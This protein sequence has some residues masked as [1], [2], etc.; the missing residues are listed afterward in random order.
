MPVNAVIQ[1]DLSIETK[2][3]YEY[4]VDPNANIQEELIPNTESPT[5][6]SFQL[7]F[8]HNHIVSEIVATID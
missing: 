3:T 7:E 6:T 4:C 8:S 5:M 1:T 2:E